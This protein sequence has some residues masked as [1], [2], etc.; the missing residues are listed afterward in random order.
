MQAPILTRRHVLALPSAL[1]L[2][3]LQGRDVH[4]PL[5]WGVGGKGWSDTARPYARL[6]RKAEKAVRGVVW[7]LAQDSAGLTVEFETDST[8]IDITVTLRS[9]QLD[10]VHMPATGVSGVDVYA[11]TE[12]GSWR[13]VACGQPRD[14]TYTLSLKGLLPGRREYR[15]YLPLYNGVDQLAIETGAG[16]YFKGLAP[17]TDKPILIYG[18]SIAQ[19]ACASRP[20]MAWPAILGRRLGRPV[21]NLGFSGNGKMEA[22][23]AALLAELDPALYVIDCL[24]NMNAP[25]VTERAAPLV[26]TLRSARPKTPIIL[27]EDRRFSNSGW[28]PSREEH[29]SGNHAALREAY[30]LL[31]EDEGV[32]GLHYVEDAPFMGADGEGA[33]DGSHPNDLGMMRWADVMAQRLRPFLED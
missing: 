24:P 9:S 22:E 17:N 18:T 19:G 1:A 15:L 28:Y 13:W 11:R 27:V 21:L 26:R 3:L 31:H 6:P 14:Q 33:V 25:L 8:A 16:S 12:E 10:M 7:N 20:G 2:P 5:T 29:H 32:G 23:V 4:D 30:R